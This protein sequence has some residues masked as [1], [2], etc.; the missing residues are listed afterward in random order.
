MAMKVSTDGGKWPPRRAFDFEAHVRTTAG[1]FATVRVCVHCG[2]REIVRK[3]RPGV[4]RGYGMRE[5]NKARGRMIAH[6][7]AEHGA[8]WRHENGGSEHG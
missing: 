8:L 5:G 1:P 4:G 3:G 7:K 6:L 2:H